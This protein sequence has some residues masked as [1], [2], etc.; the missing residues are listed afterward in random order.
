MS[1]WSNKKPVLG[2]RSTWKKHKT[3]MSSKP[4]PAIWSHDTGQRIPC[5]DRCQLTI[6]WMFNIKDTLQ[7]KA[8]RL[9]IRDFKGP[10]KR[11][12][13]VANTLLPWCFL[14]YTNWETFVADTKCFWIKSETFFVSATNVAG[15]G[16]RGNICVGN[17][18]SA[19]MC[20]RLPGP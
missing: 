1:P 11:G 14:G 2:Q 17:N 7:T 5:F 12:H 13:I 10:G 6:A 16:K 9:G 4:E 15:A 8:A 3:S 20:P 19:T 18:V